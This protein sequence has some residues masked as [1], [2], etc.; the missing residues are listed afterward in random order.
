VNDD[1]DDAVQLLR[2]LTPHGFVADDMGEVEVFHE[3]TK[4]F[5]AMMRRRSETIARYMVDARAQLETAKNEK[6]YFPCKRIDLPAA[7]RVDVP[8]SEVLMERRSPRLFAGGALSIAQLSSLL[9]WSLGKSAEVRLP[10]LGPLTT[11]VKRPYPSAGGLYPVEHYVLTLGVDGCEQAATHYSARRHA[12]DVL[13]MD[14]DA[15]AWGR[16]LGGA[17]DHLERAAIAVVS[18]ALLPRACVKYGPRGYRFALM[19][20]GHAA[21][22]LSLVAQALGFAALQWGGAYDDEVHGLLGV[23]GLTEVLVG[24]L[25]VGTHALR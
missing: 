15:D 25:F 21:M 18:T 11:L 24:A 5:P 3:S 23:D 2:Y 17:E 13:P 4:F 19:E 6:S 22:N 20:A 16:A 14:F 10:N 8:L 1:S 12:L 7:E 9:Y